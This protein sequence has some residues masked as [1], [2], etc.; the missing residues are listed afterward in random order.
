M[1]ETHP[2]KCYFWGKKEYSIHWVFIEWTSP[3][4]DMCPF[5]VSSYFSVITCLH[6]LLWLQGTD[7]DLPPSQLVNIPHL[8]ILKWKSYFVYWMVYS[9]SETTKHVELRLGWFKSQ[10]KVE[11]LLSFVYTSFLLGKAEQ[12]AVLLQIREKTHIFLA[13][14]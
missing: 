7:F 3:L 13:Y 11:Y 1:K 2:P 8:F 10:I 4:N 14:W 12:W 6:T 5:C 9:T